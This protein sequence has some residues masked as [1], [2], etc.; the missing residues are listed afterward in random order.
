MDSTIID[1]RYRLQFKAPYSHYSALP[2]FNNG[3]DRRLS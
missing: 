3:M 1:R 2:A